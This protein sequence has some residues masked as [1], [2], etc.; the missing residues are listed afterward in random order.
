MKKNLNKVVLLAK[1]KLNSTEL[2]ISK[3]L[4][5]SCINP[6]EFVSVNHM[7]IENYDVRNLISKDFNS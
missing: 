7:F 1:T 4:I 5:D 6:H 3:G 2:L